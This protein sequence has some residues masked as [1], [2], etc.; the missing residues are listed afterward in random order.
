MAS[1]SAGSTP[2]SRSRYDPNNSIQFYK[3]RLELL[4]QTL[5]RFATLQELLIPNAKEASLLTREIGKHNEDLQRIQDL[6]DALDRE[7]L[8]SSDDIRANKLQLDELETLKTSTQAQID[9]KS[10]LPQPVRQDVSY[11]F[12][13]KS[14]KSP[15]RVSGIL[16]EKPP[17]PPS[18]HHKSKRLNGMMATT[19]TTTTSSSSSHFSSIGRVTGLNING[20][21][22]SS[23]SLSLSPSSPV[24]NSPCRVKP[25]EIVQLETQLA[26]QTQHIT[27]NLEMFHRRINDAEIGIH[28]TKDKAVSSVDLDH[29]ELSLLV[30]E[31]DHLD[32]Q[33]FLAVSELFKV[34]VRM[35][36]NQREEFEELD[37]L[38]REKC[39][40]AGLEEEIIE[41]LHHDIHEITQRLRKEIIKLEQEC[42]EKELIIDQRKDKILANIEL[43][44]D[45]KRA[46][47]QVTVDKLEE[48]RTLG[49]QRV[50]HLQERHALEMEGFYAEAHMLRKRWEKALK[51]QRQ[52]QR[53]K[54]RMNQTYPSSQ[55]STHKASPF[56]SF[57]PT[58]RHVHSLGGSWGGSRPHGVV[59]AQN[60]NK[61]EGSGSAGSPRIP[62]RHH[63][64][65][66]S[67]SPR[68]TKT[69]DGSDPFAEFF[70]WTIS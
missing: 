33:C 45:E 2:T 13:S 50:I 8:Q 39:H 24:T 66:A 20:K 23:T 70:G 18:P 53:N 62:T 46:A 11:L 12:G 28:K 16:K 38:Y 68:N 17:P 41:T 52:R 27:D 55:K 63:G 30:D 19:T 61:V 4:P 1:R 57:V 58:P 29:T 42:K 6:V 7:V 36:S 69:V 15:F 48:Q 56:P 60:G 65:R 35:L 51:Q 3:A 31:N 5:S 9:H 43:C 32:Q 22:R 34:R 44:T 37:Q 14:E 10:H 49:E 47:I 59:G 21:S 67:I 25:A 40:F 26:I 54:S 64:I